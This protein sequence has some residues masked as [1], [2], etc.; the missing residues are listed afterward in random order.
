M[1]KIKESLRGCDIVLVVGDTRVS[2]DESVDAKVEW[3]LIG[4]I[5][6]RQRVYH[7]L[8]IGSRLRVFAIELSMRT[9][10]LCR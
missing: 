3:C 5:F 6:R 8:E 2:D 9:K 7:E 4:C 10:E 1:G